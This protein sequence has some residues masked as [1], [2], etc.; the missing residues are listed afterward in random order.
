MVDIFFLSA[1]C[2]LQHYA[3]AHAWRMGVVDLYNA[4]SDWSTVQKCRPTV[5]QD[6]DDKIMSATFV[7]KCEH[8]VTR[9]LDD[10]LMPQYII[11]I[12]QYLYSAIMSYADTEALVAPV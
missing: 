5:G 9:A 10:R 12:I 2:P 6:V 3:R 7:S 4:C 8:A 11:I 1:N